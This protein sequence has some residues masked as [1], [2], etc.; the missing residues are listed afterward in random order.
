MILAI[1]SFVMIFA[2]SMTLIKIYI[3]QISLEIPLTMDKILQWGAIPGTF[4]YS[5]SKSITLFNM[6]GFD[7]SSYKIEMTSVGPFNYTVTRNF[8][9]PV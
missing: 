9:K 7:S 5:Y 1:V 3:N 2:I 4:N 8:V 6:T